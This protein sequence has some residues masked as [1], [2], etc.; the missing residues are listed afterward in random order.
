MSAPNTAAMDVM[1][2][3]DKTANRFQLFG[4]SRF[5]EAA[6]L[7]VK[8]GNLFKASRHLD[9]AGKAYVKAADCY[10]R[11]SQTH[12]AATA[13]VNAAGCLRKTNGAEAVRCFKTAVDMYTAGGHFS[14]A[15]KHLQDMGELCEADND[16][17][18]AIEYF[19][20]AAEFYEGENATSRANQCLVK[21]ALMSALAEKY[22]DAVEMF[23][24]VAR[25]ALESSLL[26]W[27][28]KNYLLKAALCHLAKG[29]VVAAK[30]S[31]GRYQEWDVSFGSQREC[32]LAVAVADAYEQYDEEA[33][34]NAVV[35]YDS[36]TKLEAW[37][38]T[39]LLRIKNKL[40]EESGTSLT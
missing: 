30:T 7:Y 40:K 15:A 19:T 14:M 27:G 34:T 17:E 31:L 1:K 32:K 11:T 6:E 18:G 9:E 8:A 16:N 33:F 10:S 22:D 5:E 39:M 38:T 24:R 20:K 21:V 12:E 23:E 36:V 2:Q 4:N 26:K 37:M 29:D 28:A 3:A 35:E 13:Y 25:A